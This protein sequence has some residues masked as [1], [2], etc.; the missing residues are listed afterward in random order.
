MARL[1]WR[2]LVP[3]GLAVGLMVGTKVNLLAPAAALVVGIPLIARA[4]SAAAGPRRLRSAG[5]GGRGVLV[6]AKPGPGRQPA[7]LGQTVSPGSRLPGPDQPL[8]GRPQYSIAHYLTDGSVWDHWFLPE[9]HRRDRGALAAARSPWRASRSSPVALRG[10]PHCFRVL[11]VAALLGVAGWF[12]HGTSAEGPP[13]EPIGFFSS[14]RHVAP[15]LAVG[16]ALAPLAPGLRSPPARAVLLV[17]MLALSALRRCLR[18]P[19]DQRLP[20]AR[21][22]DRSRAS[23]PPCSPRCQRGPRSGCPGRRWRWRRR[24]ALALAVAAVWAIQVPYLEH[25]YRTR[26]DPPAGLAAAARWARHLSTPGSQRPA[27]VP[28]PC[29][30]PISPTP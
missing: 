11:A 29:S 21:G 18:G 27:T 22:R 9:L 8:G 1:S 30:A 16:L 7:S 5:A 19:L 28:T 3:A 6:S 12:F 20:R 14:L 17:A 2:A 15:S 24:G 26:H 23:S 13:G 10:P 4:G 25:R